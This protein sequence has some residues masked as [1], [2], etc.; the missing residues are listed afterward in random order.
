[1]KIAGSSIE[2]T[3]TLYNPSTTT[4]G[5]EF[6]NTSGNNTIASFSPNSASAAAS[7][8]V[9]SSDNG[10]TGATGE[11]L[12]R[13]HSKTG[14]G[15]T[16][17]A[18]LKSGN[19]P[20]GNSGNVVIEPG[21]ASGTRGKIQLKDGSEGTSGYVWTSSDTLGSGSWQ[22]LSTGNPLNIVTGVSSSF[23]GSI[24]SWLTYKDAVQAQPEDGT[25]G[26]ATITATLNTGSDRLNGA[27]SLRI[28][29]DA[30][31]RQ[32]EGISLGLTVPNFIRGLP[33]KIQF[34]A[35][36]SANFDFGTAFDSSDPSDITVYI[37]DVTN[38]IL[39]QP[40]P[41]TINSNGI[42]EGTFQ[43]ASN[44]SSMR[45]ILHVATAN[46]AAYTLDIDDVEIS[47]ALNETMKSD[48][49]LEAYTPT[50][51]GFGTV[52]SSNMFFRKTLDGIW[53][54][55]SFVAGTTTA[56]E[57]RMSLPAGLLSKNSTYIPVI[58]R[59]GSFAVGVNT[60][61]EGSVLIEP[62]VSYITFGIANGGAAEPLTK[63]NGSTVAS[64][65]NKISL[66]AFI[67]IEG[68]TSGQST[69]ASANLNAPVVFRAY[70][71]AGSATAS[72]TITSWTAK[73]IDTTNSF[74][75]STGIYTIKVPGD[76]EFSFAAQRNA[77]D[78]SI[79]QIQKNGVTVALGGSNAN[80]DY[81][82]TAVA[83][84]PNCKVGDTIIT[85]ITSGTTFASNNFA[86]VFQGKKIETNGRVYS[87]R[88]AYLKDVKSSGTTGGGFTSG[89]YQTR[90]LN[91]TEG[92]S[93][94]VSLSANQFT[95]QPGTYQIEASVPAY[96]VNFHKAK[97]RN[98]TD[99]TDAIIGSS[100]YTEN[101]AG[102]GNTRSFISGTISISSAKT[103]EIQ[104]RCG[105]TNAS[106][107]FGVASTFGDNEVYTQVKIEKVL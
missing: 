38:S 68:F 19:A 106:N 85:Q 15:N 78:T 105:T 26:S 86:T 4:S 56:T 31:N 107:G 9:Y 87:T 59:N 44:T 55:G 97:L 30:A 93:S 94:F 58:R 100:E 22:Y 5:L 73:E 10:G 104:H 101:S 46:A 83:L 42:F 28:T 57:A 48:S 62:S 102:A 39:I 45:L 67:P 65:G 98:I 52:S 77:A 1:M 29:K 12:L 37:Y 24:G 40:Y 53:I 34:N 49:D 50:Y 80:S 63:R 89:S 7:L 35:K 82:N 99:S 54:E 81:K 13:S 20:S 69:A 84:L 33:C 51:T 32:G 70:K 25:G 103:F 95:L 3:V 91:T 17:I 11:L 64:S 2:N 41:Y 61:Q 23:E 74:D 60:T 6:R 71:N 66:Y 96:F 16:G 75:T 90:V 8:L 92:D 79:I 47:P 27:G 21:T 18:S 88:V 72:S 36:G 43:I 14:S 76:Y